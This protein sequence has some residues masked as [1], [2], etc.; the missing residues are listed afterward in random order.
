[1]SL[2]Y[3]ILGFLSQQSLTGYDLKKIID[4]SIRHFWPADQ[5]QIYRTLARLTEEGKAEMELVPQADRPDRKLYHITASGRAALASW[6]RSPTPVEPNRSAA[7]IQLFFSGQLSDAEV[8][9]MLEGVADEMRAGL[10]L[11]ADIP[12]RM[13]TYAQYVESPRQFYFWMLTLEIGVNSM[14]SNLEWIEAMMGR[15]RAG[16]VP[17]A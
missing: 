2:E 8:L 16:E 10:Q 17:Q 6:L 9:Q 7:M 1:M 5:A 3:A 12:R 13:E 15:L 11:Y 4:T 14:R